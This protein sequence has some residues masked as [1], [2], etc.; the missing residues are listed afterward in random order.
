MKLDVPKC[1]KHLNN[2]K[3]SFEVKVGW[4]SY[5]KATN[6]IRM[7]EMKYNFKCRKENGLYDLIAFHLA[8]FS[9]HQ[10]FS[11]NIQELKYLLH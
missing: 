2:Q 9:K 1:R 6:S 10:G 5:T 11:W 3:N 7:S 4:D 8:P